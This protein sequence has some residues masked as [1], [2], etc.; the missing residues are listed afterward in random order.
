MP[1]A[2]LVRVDNAGVQS[3]AVPGLEVPTDEHGQ[4]WVHFNKTDPARYVSAKDVLQGNVSRGPVSRQARADR[5][6][7]DRS[8]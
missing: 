4:L 7:G 8:A 1:S 2:I 5:H 3:V 6:F